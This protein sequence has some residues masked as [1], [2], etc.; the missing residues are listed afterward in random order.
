MLNPPW[1]TQQ[2]LLNAIRSMQALARSLRQGSSLDDVTAA[3]GSS[4]PV[5][6]D[7]EHWCL[8]ARDSRLPHVLPIAGNVTLDDKCGLTSDVAAKLIRVSVTA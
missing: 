5:G 6:S 1:T 8:F 2:E 7:Q 4:I 3:T